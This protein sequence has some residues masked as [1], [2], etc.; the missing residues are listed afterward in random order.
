MALR[1]E[2]ERAGAWLFRW[3]S[4]WPFLTL[5][6]LVVALPDSELL[7][8]L[9]GNLV[10]ELYEGFCLA[11][12]CLGLALR[13]VTVGY[14]PEG[15]SGRNTKKQKA[16]TL[17]TTG[18]YS[19][20]RHPLYLG[21]F[22]IFLG[23]IL[24]VEVWWFILVSILGFVLCYVPIMY[25]EEEFLRE[26]F[27]NAYLEWAERTPAFIPKWKRWLRPDLPFAWRNVL[28]R[29]YSGFFAIVASFSCFE[30]ASDLFAEHRL[31]VDWDVR[32]LFVL[33]LATYLT[34]RTLKRKTV[35]LE[36][37]GR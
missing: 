12:C 27:G 10:N 34:L 23:M 5:P 30:I 32:V 28:K 8:R 2:L 24:F 20:V 26:K 31:A 4:Y 37:A 15:T 3:R 1:E 21:N 33:G 9:A 25:A 29:E 6:M 36:V 13:C 7:K 35:V 16:R 19:I 11:M 14:A 17:N 22:V 18:T